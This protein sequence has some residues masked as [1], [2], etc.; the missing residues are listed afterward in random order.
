MSAN[1]CYIFSSSFLLK[2]RFFTPKISR[3]A[4]RAFSTLLMTIAMNAG[5]TQIQAYNSGALQ[6]STINQNMWGEGA[7]T[8]LMNKQFFGAQWSDKT[9]SIGGI[10]GSRTSETIITNPLWWAWKAC[11]E[12][13]NVFCGGQPS[14]GEKT[15]TIDTRTGAK[16]DLTTSGKFGFELGYLIDAGSVNADVLFN[17][18][19]ELPTRSVKSGEAITLNTSSLLSDGLLTTQS[20]TAKAY[21]N[22]IA[23]LS[24][25]VTAKG[26][27]I[28][29]GCKEGGGTLVNFNETL[30]LLEVNP[31]ALEILPEALPPKNPGGDREPLLK[32]DLFNQ[33]LTLQASLDA[34]GVPGFKL[35]TNFGTLV[36]TSPTGVPSVEIDLASLEFQ[37][38][39]IQASGGVDGDI[40]KAEG[41]DDFLKLKADLDGVATLAGVVPPLGLGLSLIDIGAGAT[42]F[43]VAASL[44]VLDIDAGPDLGFAQDFELTPTLKAIVN[45]SAPVMIAGAIVEIWEGIWENFPEVTLF[46]TTTFSPTFW[47][48]AMLLH[49]LAID[50]GLSG[51]LDLFKVGLTAS[52][53]GVKLLGGDISLNQVIGLGNTLFQ[54]PRAEFDIWN[55][56]FALRGFTP[57]IGTA[58]TITVPEPATYLLFLLGILAIVV[59]YRQRVSLA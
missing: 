46:E 31:N 57:I 59:H 7:A 42:N 29:L 40:I 48:D 52:L 55:K 5:A 43:K 34:T 20:P 58:F 24:A 14:Q 26:C 10:I 2:P 6:F 9:A 16:L 54:T 19:A 25:T 39:Q 3:I 22:A 8:Q 47:L 53:G 56:S 17:A 35:S 4:L 33:Q 15:L 38:P 37:I 32:A 51:T 23:S 50:L 45:F 28:A 30:P 21:L 44:D 41:R 11:K 13:V 49:E 18:V 36:D 27:L 1:S 12:T